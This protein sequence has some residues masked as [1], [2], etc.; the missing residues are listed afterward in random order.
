MPLISG[1]EIQLMHNYIC[2]SVNDPKRIQILYA[3]HDQPLHVTALA[4]LLD[5]PQPTVSR[6]L[7]LLRQ[8]LLVT[9]ERNG[10]AVVYRLTDPRIVDVLDQ[11]RDI[12]RELLEQ[13]A[14]RLENA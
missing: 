14:G 6:H 8:R 7:A 2:Q 10:P 13:Q 4:E 3:L 9:S 5:L 1:D 11:M 12:L